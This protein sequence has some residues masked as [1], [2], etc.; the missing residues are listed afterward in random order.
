MNFLQLP[1]LFV[2][3]VFLPVEVLPGRVQFISSI[4]PITYDVD[5]TR[6]LVIR[7]WAWD[8]VLPSLGVLIALDVALGTLAVVLIRRATDASAR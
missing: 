4:N 8:T 1:F 3:S 2:S 5:A 6:A 7:G